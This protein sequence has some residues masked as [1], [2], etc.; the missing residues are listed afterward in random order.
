MTT[1]HRALADELEADAE[2][3]ASSA[4]YAVEFDGRT[5]R[6]GIAEVHPPYVIAVSRSDDTVLYQAIRQRLDPY[7]HMTGFDVV[8]EMHTDVDECRAAMRTARTGGMPDCRLERLALD[9][10]A[11]ARV[12]E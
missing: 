3:S 12:D 6:V 7:H 11:R 10:F 5:W 8:G 9:A 1:T 4:S 2:T